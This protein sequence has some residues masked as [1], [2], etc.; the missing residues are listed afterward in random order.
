MLKARGRIQSSRRSSEESGGESVF[1]VPVVRSIK[2]SVVSFFLSFYFGLQVCLPFV[3]FIYSFASGIIY[4]HIYILRSSL[5]HS[6]PFKLLFILTLS[7][8]WLTLV[9][10]SYFVVFVLFCFVFLFLV[11]VIFVSYFLYLTRYLFYHIISSL[12]PVYRFCCF[13]VPLIY[14]FLLFR[15]CLLPRDTIFCCARKQVHTCVV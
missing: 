2:Y 1:I 9:L 11:K 13:I 10:F 8:H 14:V 12:H 15:F 5:I 3:S 6:F 7:R 4:I